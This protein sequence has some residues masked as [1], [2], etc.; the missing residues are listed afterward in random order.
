MT[1]IPE[2]ETRVTKTPNAVMTTLAS[3]TQG[4][5]SELSLWRVSMTAGQ[6]GP[7]HRFDVEQAWHVVS[8]SATITMSGKRLDLETGDTVVVA[9]RESR[10]IATETG[11]EFLVTGQ[12]A[13]LATPVTPEGDGEPVAPAWVL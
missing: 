8:G 6:A 13:G 4:D 2:T 7:E 5:T 12:A 10:R 3:P 9:A 1:L 11:V